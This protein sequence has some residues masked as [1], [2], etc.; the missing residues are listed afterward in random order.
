MQ[1]FG[2]ATGQ[3]ETQQM[4]GALAIYSGL[5]YGVFNISLLDGTECGDRPDLESRLA[6]CARFFGSR[7]TRW[8]FWLCEDLV[9]RSKLRPIRDMMASRGF[10]Q[11]SQAPGMVADELAV[12]QRALPPIE[13]APV[14][15]A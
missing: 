14:R 13:F 12:S 1:F 8:S 5:E 10:R 7:T 4:E 15:D 6:R 2:A 9:G 3:G 11:I